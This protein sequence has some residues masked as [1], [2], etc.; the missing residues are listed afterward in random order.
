MH[1]S[2]GARAFV[3]RRSAQ[4]RVSATSEPEDEG[5]GGEGRGGE[6]RGAVRGGQPDL[7]RGDG[8]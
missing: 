1:L 3:A 6:G 8:E 2:A 4:M 7:E 5:K